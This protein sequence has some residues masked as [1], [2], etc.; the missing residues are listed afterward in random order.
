MVVPFYILLKYP[1][2]SCY[3]S[4]LLCRVV[5]NFNF[6]YSGGWVVDFNIVLNYVNW[7]TNIFEPLLFLNLA[8]LCVFCE[9]NV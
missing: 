8:H 9:I 4:L 3:T 6:S 1:R 7:M 2:S 5:S